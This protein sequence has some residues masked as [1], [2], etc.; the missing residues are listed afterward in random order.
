MTNIAPIDPHQSR[1]SMEARRGRSSRLRLTRRRLHNAAMQYFGP[2]PDFAIES[3]RGTIAGELDIP[4]F[5]SKYAWPYLVRRGG[6]IIINV[7]SIAGMIAGET[8]TM[9]AHVAANAGVIAMTGNSR[10][11]ARQMAYAR[12]RSV[13]VRS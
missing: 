9:V 12:L 7:A 1:T 6:G 2:M 11:K 3:W 13:P 10:L 8:P 4:F 5:V